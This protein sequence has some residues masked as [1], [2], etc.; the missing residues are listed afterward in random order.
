MKYIQAIEIFGSHTDK[1]QEWWW[2]FRQSSVGAMESYW[3]IQSGSET[4]RRLIENPCCRTNEQVHCAVTRFWNIKLQGAM[5][6]SYI[7]DKQAALLLG[8]LFLYKPCWSQ[9]SD[10]CSHFLAETKLLRMFFFFFYIINTQANCVG[11]WSSVSL[12]GICLVPVL[13]CF[14]WK[15][16]LKGMM[17]S[18]TVNKNWNSIK[19]N[20]DVFH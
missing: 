17:S 14:G 2:L 5:L 10:P 3:A 16:I 6:S 11:N 19:A 4:F 9:D 15:I 1:E 8:S 13:I 18:S 20:S 12:T 7:T